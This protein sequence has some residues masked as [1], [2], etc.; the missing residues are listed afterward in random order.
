M[1][2]SVVHLQKKGARLKARERVMP[3]GGKVSAK[4][5]DNGTQQKEARDTVS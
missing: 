2:K 5:A 1:P 4:V 3:N